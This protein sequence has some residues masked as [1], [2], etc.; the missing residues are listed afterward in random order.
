MSGGIVAGTSL[1]LGACLRNMSELKAR[2]RCFRNFAV[3]IMDFFGHEVGP[4]KIARQKSLK[5]R[6][7]IQ[8]LAPIP[9]HSQGDGVRE[10]WSVAPQ[11]PPGLFFFAVD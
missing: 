10:P 1:A 2:A 7:V 4:K 9:P 6:S 5:E 11:L 3:R 8:P